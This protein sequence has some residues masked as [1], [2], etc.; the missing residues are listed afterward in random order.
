MNKVLFWMGGLV[1]A[2]LLFVPFACATLEQAAR[3][4]A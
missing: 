4:L 1:T 3:I 2:S